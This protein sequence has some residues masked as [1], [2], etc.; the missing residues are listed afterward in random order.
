MYPIN[1]RKHAKF[2]AHTIPC[3]PM[4]IYMLIK[5]SNEFVDI[6]HKM[7]IDKVR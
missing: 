5:Y 2:N 1:N 7:L 4:D 6:V 3:V